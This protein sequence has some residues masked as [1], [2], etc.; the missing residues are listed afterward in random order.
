V[1]AQSA[2]HHRD[3]VKWIGLAA[4]SDPGLLPQHVAAA[5]GIREGPGRPVNAALVDAL[6]DCA[7]ML[8]LY[9]C[10]HMADAAV[11]VVETLIRGCSASGVW[12][13]AAVQEASDR[14]NPFTRTPCA[15]WRPRRIL[16]G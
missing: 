11:I 7:S 9:N 13:A 16:S 8:V 5:L 6:R 10:E 14:R 12:C 4:L 15:G 1:A 2:G 3:G